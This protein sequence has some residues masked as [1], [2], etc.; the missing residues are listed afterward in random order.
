MDI[1]DREIFSNLTIFPPFLSG[2]T[3]GPFIV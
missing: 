2:S 1:K 3:A